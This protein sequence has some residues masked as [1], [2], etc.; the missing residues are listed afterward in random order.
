MSMEIHFY[1]YSV[2]IKEYFLIHCEMTQDY[3]VSVHYVFMCECVPA[4]VCQEF[5][6]FGSVRKTS[7]GHLRMHALPKCG[8]WPF[9]RVGKTEII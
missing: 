1:K 6:S 3:N 5:R 2:R 7:G 9:G 8:F 4:V